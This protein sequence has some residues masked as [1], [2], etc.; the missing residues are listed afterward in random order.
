MMHSRT[1]AV[2][3][4]TGQA[5]LVAA[6]ATLASCLLV[7]DAHAQ[8]WKDDKPGISS[9]MAPELV[10]V[11]IVEHLGQPLP[12]DATFRDTEGKQVKLGDYFDGK[13]PVL[14]VFAYHTCPMLCS[15]VLDAT[16]KSLNDVVWTVG[17]QFDVVSVSIDPHDSPETATRKREQ[18]VNS[19]PRARGSTKGFHFLTGDETNIRKVTEAIGFKYR[20]DERQKQYAHPAAIYLLTPAG[21][22]ARYLY[23]IMYAPADVR[24]GL[25]EASQGRSI[26]TTERVL[27][28]CYHY[29][30]QGGHYSL[31]AMNVMRLGGVVT[32]VTLGSFLTIM[33]ARERRRRKAGKDAHHARGPLGAHSS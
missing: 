8:Q 18:V 2:S 28:Y 32:L 24:L 5:A 7:G 15:L 3:A 31:V 25:L 10:G 27:L 19:Y 14:F 9:T 23:G 6:A 11:D 21:N 13:R 30:P 22:L 12:A 33:W 4:L 29:D 20:Y 26:S 16:V 1:A 17:D